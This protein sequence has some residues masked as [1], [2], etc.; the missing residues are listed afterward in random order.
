MT[1]SWPEL[2]EELAR[3]AMERISNDVG[4]YQ[5]GELQAGRVYITADVLA[6]VT[7][8]LIDNETWQTIYAVRQEMAKIINDAARGK[9]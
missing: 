1:G 5:D 8:G 6:D 2:G 3:K 9:K 7:Q 4:R